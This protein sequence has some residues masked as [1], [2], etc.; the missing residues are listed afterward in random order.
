MKQHRSFC[1]NNSNGS[2]FLLL[3][4]RMKYYVGN[5]LVSGWKQVLPSALLILLG[6]ALACGIV[7]LCLPVYQWFIFSCGMSKAVLRC[8]GWD[9]FFL[10]F[11]CI[12]HNSFLIRQLK[13]TVWFC[14]AVSIF[15]CSLVFLTV[16]QWLALSVFSY[17]LLRL[18]FITKSLTEELLFGNPGCLVW[19]LTEIKFEHTSQE[20]RIFWQS[21]SLW[22]KE[23]LPIFHACLLTVNRTTTVSNT[24]GTLCENGILFFSFPL[25]SYKI[26]LLEII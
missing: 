17:V 6:S 5:V 14:L 25:T 8:F 24:E 11:G 9:F 16:P 4:W 19:G 15:I 3:F 18:T 1:L 7:L 13:L 21:Y 22:I 20:K 12:A 26:K 23:I 2:S 10:H